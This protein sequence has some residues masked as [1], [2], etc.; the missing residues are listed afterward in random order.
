MS[1]FRRVPGLIRSRRNPDNDLGVRPRGGVAEFFCILDLQ[2]CR[3]RFVLSVR[4]KIAELAFRVFGRSL[5]PELYSVHQVR[6]IQR[7]LYQATIEITN[8]GHV[9]T[10][11]GGGATLCEVATGACQPL[12]TR[13]CLISLPLK[14]SRTEN[15]QCQDGV[16]YRTHFH[17]DTVA[18]EMFW[19][20]NQQL[21]G[22]STQGLLHRFESSGRL[23]FGAI[24]YISVETR[25]ASMLVQAI[26]TFPDDYAILKIESLFSL[27]AATSKSNAGSI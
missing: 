8:C 2:P 1:P 17:L 15:A 18:P 16:V 10:W 3:D 24:S 23:A 14:G 22:D 4:P 26:H 27:P 13:R 5:H 12:P 7:K 6:S 25:S 20:V 19:L 21:T 9:I 11:R